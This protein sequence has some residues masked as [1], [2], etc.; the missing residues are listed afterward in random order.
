MVDAV[1]EHGRLDFKMYPPPPPA[2]PGHAAGGQVHHVLLHV[3]QPAQPEGVEE[4][5]VALGVA[6]IVRDVQA[7]LQVQ[8]GVC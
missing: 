8:G 4:G 7:W 2:R 1:L 3:H 6:C 5:V